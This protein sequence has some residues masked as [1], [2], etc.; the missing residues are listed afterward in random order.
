[1]DE[2]REFS[3]LVGRIYDASLDPSQWPAVLAGIADYVPGAFV[4]LFAQDAAR[5]EAQAFYSHG[6]TPEYLQLYFDKYIH[7]NPMFPAMLFFEVGR[8]I[9]IEDVMPHE[10]FAQTVFFKEWVKPQGFLESSMAAILDKSGTRLSG[11]AVAPG[12]SH[13]Q[14]TAASLRRME[15]IVPHVRRAM[16]VGN[17]IEQHKV[18]AA[19]LGDTLDGIAAGMFLVDASANLVRANARGLAMLEQGTVLRAVGRSLV[20]ADTQARAALQESLAL[21]AAGDASLGA[22]SV[23]IPIGGTDQPHVAHLLPLTAGSRRRAGA[24]YA[25]VAALF[26]REAELDVAHPVETLA[27]AFRLTPSEM[28]VLMMIVQLGGVPQVA[29]V[30]GVS[31]TTVRTHLQQIFAKTGVG[32]QADLVKLVASYMNPLASG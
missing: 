32:R 6:I 22:R 16:L 3:D 26:V 12:R 28:R 25:A 27:H 5:P 19:E 1:M 17:V 21:A 13:G 14:V 2:T 8:V 9:G 23:S 7:I 29:P 10:E 24:A 18:D 31:E 11:I 30:L 4:N 20:L 15:L